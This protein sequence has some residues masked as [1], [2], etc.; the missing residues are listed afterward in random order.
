M[1]ANRLAAAEALLDLGRV[2]AA[3]RLVGQVLG[4]QPDSLV[5]T[6]LLARCHLEAGRGGEAFAAAER[7]VALAPDD[8][9]AHQLRALALVS[10]GRH[11]HAAAAARE[12][13]R[14]A[15]DAAGIHV[16]LADALLA[17]GGTRNILAAGAA[18][19]RAHRLDP[20]LAAAH[21]AAGDVWLCR[22]EFRR[23]RQAYC[24]A[25]RLAPDDVLVRHRLAALDSAR[26][27]ILQS[28]QGFG[29]VLRQA[30]TS[31]PVQQDARAGARRALWRLTDLLSVVALVPTGAAFLAGPVPD[32]LGTLGLLW[33]AYTLMGKLSAATR[34]LIR[35]NLARPV[36]GLAFARV[37][38]VLVAPAVPALAGPLIGVPMVL[39]VVR[40]R[41]LV[42]AEVVF[43][44]RRLWF[45]LC[46]R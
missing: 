32:V 33:L 29:A 25:L 13:I 19:A 37:A 31:V 46:Q 3:L 26:G 42:V 30:P 18:A 10:L 35:R 1:T 17:A 21:R 22:A 28:S 6:R 24:A 16:L 5:A 20:A 23:A 38:A 2:D 8:P 44:A 14:L 9:V 11:G 4:A 27:R 43:A 39:L 7:A 34:V 15:P 12:A 41:G 40:V 36:F 45:R